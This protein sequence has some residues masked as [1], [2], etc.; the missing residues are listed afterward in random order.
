MLEAGFSVRG[1]VRSASKADHFRN[2]FKSLGGKFEVVVVPDITNDS[3]DEASHTKDRSS[4]TL[5]WEWYEGCK[6]KLG[7]E[8]VALNPPWYSNIAKEKLSPD[9]CIN[10]QWRESVPECSPFAYDHRKAKPGEVDNNSK[11]NLG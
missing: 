4:K 6:C 8:L 9:G 5:A 11:S 10:I 1:T 7:W 3:I 2:L